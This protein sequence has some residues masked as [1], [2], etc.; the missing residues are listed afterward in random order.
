[1]DNVGVDLILVGDFL[2]MVILGY[3]II[4]LVI[5]EEMIYYVKVVWWVVK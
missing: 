5:F 4:L 1:M 3:E 2:G